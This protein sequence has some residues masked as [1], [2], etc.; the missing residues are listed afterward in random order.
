MR[1]LA[2]LVT[3]AAILAPA[4]LLAQSPLAEAAEKEKERRKTAA[5]AKSFTDEDLRHAGQK[6]TYSEPASDATGT[7]A[8]P[9]QA[10]KDK[11]PNAPGTKPKEK[12]ED[13]IRADKSKDWH[14]RLDKARADV[15][16][17]TKAVAEM[18]ALVADPYASNS[19]ARARLI[20][21]KEQKQKELAAANQSRATIEDEGRRNGFR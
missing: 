17:L 20:A 10:S 12:T 19:P 3:S 18:E 14:K 5:A 11:A 2:A 6:G 8:S 1:I 15:E 4:G 16:S 7:N 21:E 9:D 13:E